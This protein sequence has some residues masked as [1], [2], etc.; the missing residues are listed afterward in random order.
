MAEN[1]KKGRAPN[2]NFNIK[3]TVYSGSP[4]ELKALSRLVVGGMKSNE[5]LK[6]LDVKAIIPK[7]VI[8][9]GDFSAEQ[10]AALLESM[11]SETTDDE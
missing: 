1:A 8:E 5:A 2:K 9:L 4:K 3:G 7:D 11:T 10:A 6:V